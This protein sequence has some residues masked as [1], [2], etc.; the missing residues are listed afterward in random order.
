MSSFPVV[1]PKIME[2][3]S[4]G[5]AFCAG[6]A[7]GVWKDLQEIRDLWSVADTFEPSMAPSAREKNW[8]GWQKAITKSLEWIDE[9]DEEDEFHD[10]FQD[11]F[12]LS[13]LSPKTIFRRSSS[14]LKGGDKNGGGYSTASLLLMTAIGFGAGVLLGQRN[15]GK[16][17]L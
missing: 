6:L 12:E 17:K 7:V 3:T 5:A 9:D 2:T 16:L 1:K 15:N 4:M 11:G 14:F 13:K 8:A 10:S